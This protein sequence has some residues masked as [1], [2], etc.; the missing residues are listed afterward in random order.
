MQEKKIN[1]FFFFSEK[2][3]TSSSSKQSR[4]NQ[5]ESKKQSTALVERTRR[6]QTKPRNSVSI[7]NVSSPQDDFAKLFLKKLDIIANINIGINSSILHGICVTNDNLIWVNYST[8]H[9]KLFDSAG[10]ILR[11]VDLEQTTV[12]NCCT[13]NG[14]LLFTQ[15]YANGARAEVIM[16][17][18][19]GHPRRLAD[20][21]S[22]AKNLCGLLCQEEMIYIVCHGKAPLKYFVI[23]LDMEGEV[24]E[25][26]RAS[27]KNVNINHII[28]HYGRLYVMGT[29]NSSMFPL[30]ND[31]IST[32]DKANKVS[33]WNTYPA[34]ACVDN[35]GNVLIGSEST[36]CLLDPS[37]QRLHKIQT[38]ISGSIRSTA[39]DHRDQLWIGTNEGNLYAAHY[40]SI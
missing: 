13:P 38:D 21:S 12:F 36:I 19:E 22:Y 29:N 23:K 7:A 35:H 5:T 17:P 9:V 25:T 2:N 40:I 4:T 24:K 18:R 37:L 15:G 33:L 27:P 34:S 14:D 31:K 32:K 10:N 39:V 1:D 3:A 30:E 8:N 20:L 11:S 16:V 6:R 28:S 26:Y